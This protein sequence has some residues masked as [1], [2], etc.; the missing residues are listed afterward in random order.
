MPATAIGCVLDGFPMLRKKVV[1][2]PQMAESE[3]RIPAGFTS[4]FT[5]GL[6]VPMARAPIGGAPSMMPTRPLPLRLAV[7]PVRSTW[8]MVVSTCTSPAW[9]LI[10]PVKGVVG[11]SSSRPAP[12]LMSCSV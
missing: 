6:T 8:P 1:L 2:A 7:G 12:V 10:G 9:M 11:A 3:L 5:P 4:Q